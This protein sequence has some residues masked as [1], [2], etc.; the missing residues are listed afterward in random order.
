MKIKNQNLKHLLM[1][2]IRDY[3][4]VFYEE[5]GVILISKIAH[6]EQVHL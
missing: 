5:E 1:E 6:R 4:V 3:R 2:R